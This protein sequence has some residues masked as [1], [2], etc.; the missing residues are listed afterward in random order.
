[1]APEMPTAMY[2]S[3]ATT[4]PVWPTCMSFG[5]KPASTAAREAPAA[6]PSFE[7][8][9]PPLADVVRDINKY[10][11]NLM[12]RQLFLT[13][14]LVAHP[15]RAA[16][17]ESARAMLRGWLEARLGALPPGVA[18]DNGA[19]LSRDGRLTARLL[20]RLLVQAWDGPNQPELVASLPIFG[21]DG[22]LR[23]V[24]PA[25]GTAHLKTGSLRDV[26]GLAGYVRSES[27]RRYVLV[28]IV[29][30]P[31]ANAARPALEALVRWT[32]HDA[33]R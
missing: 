14:D 17:A 12:A 25:A 27:G 6:A 1:M 15:Q 30:H 22:T 8:V 21:V 13:L 11:N 2:S 3:G 33:V 19:G 26:S 24:A 5:T 23:R 32:L 31:E 10:S 7:F 29:N 20:A 4:L 16:D 28:A 18:L 9:S